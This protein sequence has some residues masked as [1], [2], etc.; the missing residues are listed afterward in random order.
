[1]NSNY[2]KPV[3]F[4]AFANSYEPGRQLKQLKSERWAIEAVLEEDAQELC[5]LIS[6]PSTD[7]SYLFRKL[8][9]RETRE[10]LAIFHFGGHAGGGK[11]SLE[12]AEGGEDP[13]NIDTLATFFGNAPNLKLVFLNGCASVSMVDKLLAAGVPAVI[14]TDRNIPDEEAADLSQTFYKALAGG[15]SIGDAFTLA[16]DLIENQYRHAFVQ[17]WA[18][19][20][21]QLSWDDLPKVPGE[22]FPWGIYLQPDT[23]VL[24]WTLTQHGEETVKEAPVPGWKK[25]FQRHGKKIALGMGGLVILAFLGW[26]LSDLFAGE[27]TRFD[28]PENFN[29]LIK[30]YERE[31]LKASSFEDNLLRNLS[32]ALGTSVK[33][34]TSGGIDLLVQP[35]GFDQSRNADLVIEGILQNGQGD[36]PVSLLSSFQL[37]ETSNRIGPRKADQRTP[38]GTGSHDRLPFEDYLAAT[39]VQSPLVQKL[40]EIII[41]AW[42]YEAYAEESYDEAISRWQKITPQPASSATYSPLHLALAISHLN[43]AQP[44]EA[45]ALEH[46]NAFLEQDSTLGAYYYRG[47]IYYNQE[48]YEQA[49][50]D[51]AW[52]LNPGRTEDL[53]GNQFKVVVDTREVLEQRLNANLFLNR[54]N[55]ALQDLDRWLSHDSTQWEIYI[56]RGKLRQQAKLYT[57]A[58]K[59]FERVL[60]MDPDNQEGLFARGNFYTDRFIYYEEQGE[61]L[62]PE[63]AEKRENR[64]NLARNALQKGADLYPEDPRFPLALTRLYRERD[65]AAAARASLDK[66]SA[67]IETGNVAPEFA[68]DLAY[69]WG[70]YYKDKSRDS[71][72]KYFSR[73]LSL[74]PDHGMSLYEMGNLYFVYRDYRNHDSAIVYYQQ[75]I[76]A[77]DSLHP[78]TF[79]NLGEIYQGRQAYADARAAYEKGLALLEPDKSRRHFVLLGRIM[80]YQY[81]SDFGQICGAL[82]SLN[83]TAEELGLN[84]R[85][86]RIIRRDAGPCG[87][88][89][90]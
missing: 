69:A 45:S 6:E 24:T 73:A 87:R 28:D 49:L 9:R 10:R 23:K 29:V 3:I 71:M 47:R 12:S 89:V 88:I 85:Q 30:P 14:A 33:T 67:L 50:Q 86:Q 83:V 41:W 8:S 13:T 68:V 19:A 44:E 72:Y 56:R 51:Y 32:I 75:A 60:A 76:A 46:L 48:K 59:D 18:E 81:P 11:I 63:E 43:K 2:P 17:H 55:E 22:S 35:K 34:D 16:K 79:L 7:L 78:W 37:S 84:N 82:T 26:Y 36:A 74:N 27:R 57:E 39:D 38:D 66:A 77:T 4:L 62:R 54:V 64:F 70:M 80:A 58:D 53:Y 20:H 5:D 21:R 61:R 40:S 15:M 1:M 52:V 25:I 42:G 65:M 31:G 90:E